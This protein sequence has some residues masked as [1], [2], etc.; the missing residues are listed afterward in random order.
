MLLAERP[1][2]TEL[3]NNKE[4]VMNFILSNQGELPFNLELMSPIDVCL[5][6]QNVE[7]AKL[8]NLI[9]LVLEQPLSLRNYIIMMKATPML[10][11]LDT[12]Q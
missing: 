6:Q 5:A 2:I 4:L 9:S 1:E 7:L 3:I 10:L 8:D 11:E 12:M